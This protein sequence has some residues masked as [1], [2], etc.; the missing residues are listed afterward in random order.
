M[1]R[2]PTLKRIGGAGLVILVAASACVTRQE[3]RDFYVWLDEEPENGVAIRGVPPFSAG[4][5]GGAA[6]LNAIAAFWKA[7]GGLVSRAEVQLLDPEGLLGDTEQLTQLA[8]RRGLWG[9]A[10]Y[11][12][13]DAMKT[14]LTAGVPVMAI[15]QDDSGRRETRRY[16]VVIGYHDDAR[17][18][19]VLD[20]ARRERAVDYTEFRALWRPVRQWMMT[21]TPP[22]KADWPMDVRERVALA[23][24]WERAGNWMQAIEEYRIAEKQDPMN[25]DLTLAE[26]L[27]WQRVGAWHQAEDLYRRVLAVDDLKARAANNL[28]VVLIESGGDLKEAERWVRRALTIEPANPY[29][30]DTLGH[31]LLDGGR[32]R[33]AADVLA[34]A[35]YRARQL[36]PPVQREIIARLITAYRQSDQEHLARQVLED[37]RRGDPEFVDPDDR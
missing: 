10:F 13:A 17:Q 25:L 18:W 22:G 31:V 26:A 14:R 27:A 3:R 28:A 34:R 8:D 15:V 9:Y 7:P 35:R 33:E 5:S 12:S 11:G 23:R 24:F 37:Y 32:P 2:F 29:F 4:D 21:V 1:R 16:V 20:G 19:L 6:A 36:P 30:L